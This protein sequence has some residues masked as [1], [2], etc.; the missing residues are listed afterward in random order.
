[1]IWK[2]KIKMKTESGHRIISIDDNTVRILKEWIK[3]QEKMGKF[4]FLLHR[5]SIRKINNMEYC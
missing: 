2:S 4:D 3:R 1:M 5:I